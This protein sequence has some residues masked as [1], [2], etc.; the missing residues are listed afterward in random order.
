MTRSPP[1]SSLPAGA[2]PS[3]NSAMRPSANAIQPRSITRSAR[4]ILAL[5]RTVSD[6]VEFISSIFLHAAAANDVTSTIRSAIRWRISSSWTIATMATPWRFFSIDQLDHDGAVGRIERGGRLVQQQDRQIGDEAA[7]D[8][9]A[10]LLA[11]GEGRGRQR[12]QP[13]GNV[14]PAQQTALPVRAPRRAPPRSRSAAR[15]PRRWS[16]PA[17]PRAGT[18]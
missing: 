2:L 6:S 13:L 12:P 8:V 14:E 7:R 10:L 11:A 4:T 15:R 9:D 18:G 1:A 17:A 5:P 3:P 16:Q